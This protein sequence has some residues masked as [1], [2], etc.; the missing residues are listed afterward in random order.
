M[1]LPSTDKNT[2]N[3]DNIC[4][5]PN[6]LV[7]HAQKMGMF[8][9]KHTFLSLNLSLSTVHHLLR[10]KTNFMHSSNQM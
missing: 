3:L 8:Q 10:P 6:L 5:D 4:G 1:L 7:K 9:Q 2:Y